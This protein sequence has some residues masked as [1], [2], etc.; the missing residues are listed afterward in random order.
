MREVTRIVFH[1]SASPRDTTT[2]AMIENWHTHG[3][4]WSAIGYHYVIEG[5]GFVVRGR[6]LDRQGAHAKG[7]NDDS[8]GICIVGDNTNPDQRWTQPQIDSA[9]LM[10]SSLRAVLGRDLAVYGHREVGTTPTLC[11]GVDVFDILSF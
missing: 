9:N 10:I 2:A 4:G 6:D 5:T 7:A 8:V 3:H 11:P 1:H